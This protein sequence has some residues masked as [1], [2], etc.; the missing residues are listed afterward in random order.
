MSTFKTVLLASLSL[1]FDPAIGKLEAAPSTVAEDREMAVERQSRHL[2]QDSTIGDLIRHPAFK[3]FGG[4]ILPWDDRAYDYRMKLSEVGDL[5][6]YHS[7][8]DTETDDGSASLHLHAVLGLS[9]GSTRGGHF[10]EGQVRPTLQVVIR[11]TP[12]RLR[13]KHRRDLG[14]ALIDLD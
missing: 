12:A 1:L 6:P 7:H 3:G 13:R 5:L 11:E 8:V 2:S 10:V 9:D 14:L 4:L